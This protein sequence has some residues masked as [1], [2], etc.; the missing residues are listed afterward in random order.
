[1]RDAFA[2]AAVLV[3]LVGSHT[4]CGQAGDAGQAAEAP[5]A[6]MEVAG[7]A[8]VAAASLLS[9][10]ARLEGGLA[11]EHR[12][13]EN[14]ARD[15]YRHP[16]ETLGFLGIEP[17]MVVAEISPGG[18]WYTEILAP[19]LRDEGTLYAAGADPESESE[20]AQRS[21]KR[22]MDKLA[23][24]PE[25]YDR[26]VVTVLA[27]GKREIAPRGSADAVLTFRNVHNWLAG[28]SAEAVFQEMFAALKPGGILGVVEHRGD[29]ESD[30]D[31]KAAS[32]YVRQ[33]FVIA[34]V[35][36]VGFELLESSEI[37][38]NPSDTRDHPKGVWTLPP[39]YRLEDVDR[40]KY[41]GIGESDRMTLKFRKPEV[42]S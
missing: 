1:M 12:S 9:A 17:D 25:V 21:A 10:A 39:S 3:L 13:E 34:L 26:T 19:L 40:E 18:G 6:T 5:A 32:G 31:P 42:A 41:A 35:E 14:R 4:G 28:D 27:P 38:A 23:A 8:D 20:Y 7:Q 11:G 36:S 29:P 22:F 33:D 37:N 15:V 2:Y 24:H 30:Q 16:V